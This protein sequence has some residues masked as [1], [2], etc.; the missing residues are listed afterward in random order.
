LSHRRRRHRRLVVASCAPQLRQAGRK[1]PRLQRYR[2]RVFSTLLMFSAWVECRDRN[3][4][5]AM[6]RSVA[7]RSRM[8]LHDLTAWARSGRPASTRGAVLNVA[9][10]PEP[11]G[12]WPART[13]WVDD[14]GIDFMRGPGS[15]GS[16]FSRHSAAAAGGLPL[17]LRRITWVRSCASRFS[18]MGSIWSYAGQWRFRYLTPVFAAFYSFVPL[19]IHSLW[20]RVAHQVNRKRRW[21]L[22]RNHDSAA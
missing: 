21:V 19:N 13:S 8:A 20:E 9:A 4:P 22:L 11:L 15:P 3:S 12:P 10:G 1:R 6:T 16:R 18:K 7:M 5:I 17:K 2:Q 14:S